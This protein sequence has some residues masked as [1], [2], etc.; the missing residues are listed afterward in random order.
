MAV[1]TDVKR[2]EVWGKIMQWMSADRIGITGMTKQDLRDA[3]NA[4]DA[5]ID[6]NVASFNNALPNAAKVNL[7][8]KQKLNLFSAV[9]DARWEVN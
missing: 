7:T 8:A 9:A 6:A 3:L 5:W 1:L 4:T 2:S